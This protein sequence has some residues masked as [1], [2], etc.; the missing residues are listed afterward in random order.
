MFAFP[1]Y[2]SRTA[3]SLFTVA[4]GLLTPLSAQAAPFHPSA[5]GTLNVD[6]RATYYDGSNGTLFQRVALPAGAT[7]LQFSVNGGVI[8]DGSNNLASADGLYSGGTAPY[9][10]SNTSFAGTYQ[11]VRIGSSTGVDPALMGVFFNP[12]FVG[13][14]LDSLNY[15]SDNPTNNG[16]STDLRVQLTNSPVA[17]QPFFIGDGF[18]GIDFG[19]APPYPQ[20]GS[21]QT[22]I[23]PTGATF[24]LLGIGADVN[25]ADNNNQSGATTGFR[26]QVFDD[27]P[28]ASVPEPASLVMLGAGALAVLFLAAKHRPAAVS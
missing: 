11:G 23:I 27:S 19:T 25:L 28:L 13:T 16:S 5:L 7:A 9:N 6:S 3:W 20:T 22:F 15:R 10:F 8:T 1:S 18:T 21:M 17:N 24:L 4:C 12:S 14:P 2:R 26:V